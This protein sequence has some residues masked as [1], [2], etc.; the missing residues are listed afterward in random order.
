MSDYM[1]QVSGYTHQRLLGTGASGQVFLAVHDATGT[2]VAIK[3]LS[4][5]LAVDPAFRA[6]FRGEAAML[7]EIDDPNVARLYEYVESPAGSAIVMELV[8]GVSLRQMLARH[9]PT[10]PETAL[11]VLKG[12]L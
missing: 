5:Q 7:A 3:Y 6:G 8:D 11:Y 1:W 9:G 2:P 4:P 10:D 12:S